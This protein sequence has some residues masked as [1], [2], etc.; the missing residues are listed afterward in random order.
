MHISDKS[1]NKPAD[2]PTIQSA[3]SDIQHFAQV[4][5]L[6]VT[7]NQKDQRIDNFLMA[8]LKGLPKSRIYK[9]IRDGEIRVNKGRV[10]PHTKL[11]IGD[12]V[13]IA[14]IRL[15]TRDA[16][17]IS[18]SFAKVLLERIVFEDERIIVL[19]KPSGMAVHGG[20]GVSA[21][22]IEAMRSATGKKYL[23]LVH[24]ID[25]DTS[26]LLLI[27]KKRSALKQ[28]QDMFREKT[29]QK[30]YQAIVYGSVKQDSQRVDAPLKRYELA[31]GERRVKVAA[32]GKPSVT[33]VNVLQRLKNATL[34][35][36]KPKTG[37]THQIR[38]HGLHIGHPL[39]GDNKYHQNDTS[40]AK[41]LCLHAWKLSVPEYGA[42][43]AP[44]PEDMVQLIETLSIK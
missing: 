43:E 14:P 37:R 34:I 22:V 8:R 33:D 19:N 13:R 24:R 10:K 32:D 40:A 17:Q 41:R 6:K 21:G 9:L 3:D 27:A 26:G 30:S 5:Y 29:V 16:P 11:D 23:E 4:N 31:N 7:P 36:A 35:L 28:I 25:K 1:S 2:K 15:Q 39:L 18:E 44:V 42:F 12:V 38:V 20:S